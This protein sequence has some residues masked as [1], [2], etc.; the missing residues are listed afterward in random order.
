MLQ[1]M[2]GD[3]LLEVSAATTPDDVLLLRE[4]LHTGS[5]PSVRLA[6]DSTGGLTP[7]VV[8][9]ANCGTAMRFLTAYYACLDGAH[10]VLDG[11]ERMHH[12]PIGQLVDALLDVG[13][14]IRYP[15]EE[16]YP[17]LEIHGRELDR[18]QPIHICRPQS[19]QFVSALML[20]GFE[21]TTDIISPYIELTRSIVRDYA[22]V[23]GQWSN[24]QCERDW[25]SAAFW[26]ERWTLGLCDEPQFPGLRED[27]MQGDRVARDIFNMI[28]P[29]SSVSSERLFRAFLHPQ[30]GS[31]CPLPQGRVREGLTLDCTAIPDLVPAI[32]VTCHELGLNVHLTGTE[33][34]RIKES[35]RID[36]LEQNFRLLDAAK[37][38]PYEPVL[39]SYGDHRIAMAFLA[40]GYK[41]DDIRCIDKSYPQCYEQLCSTS[42]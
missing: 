21:V 27:S 30:G 8:A 17:P 40:A 4:L 32:A 12:R 16:G 5:D 15:G 14:D 1:A 3:P 31:A 24:G 28:K 26:L 11:C 22:M 38:L 25:S 20:A 41:V 13:A 37:G 34:L 35:D 42:R 19:T 23:N 39:H 18:T 10:V 29:P 7:R 9:C 6:E 33:S 2:H 36:A